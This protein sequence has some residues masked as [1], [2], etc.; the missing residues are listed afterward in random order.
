MW[1]AGAQHG[2]YAVLVYY[3]RHPKPQADRLG[4]RLEP[5][6]DKFLAA[7]DVVRAPLYL[8]RALLQQPEALQYPS[9]VL[10]PRQGPGRLPPARCPCLDGLWPLHACKKWFLCAR[11]THAWVLANEAT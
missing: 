6:L 4:A 3:G 8:N 2:W 9:H 1:R 7:C 11:Q 10:T 5:D